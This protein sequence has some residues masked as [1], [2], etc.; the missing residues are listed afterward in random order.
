[1]F[2]LP[3]VPSADDLIDGCFR[4]GSKEAKKIRSTRK[5]KEVRMRLSEEERIHCI[6]RRICGELSSI[7]KSF[8]SYGK[9]PPFYKKLFDIQVDKDEYKK[10]LGALSWVCAR[11]SAIENESVHAVRTGKPHASK[12]FLGKTSSLLTRVSGSLDYLKDVKGKLSS[13][14]VIKELPTLVVAGYPNVG[15]ST[16][17]RNLTGSKIEV[18][19]Y[20]FTTKGLLIGYAKLGHK[21]IQVIDSPGLLDRPMSARNKIELQAVLALQEL[22]DKILFLFDP[23]MEFKPQLELLAEVSNKFTAD[24]FVGVNKADAADKIL[25]SEA[26]NE[27]S[28]YRV[29]ALSANEPE[30]CRRVFEGV[31]A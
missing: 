15:K 12:H 1:M 5:P 16:F 7:V 14:P 6:S 8:P 2:K 21:T 24:L 19:S 13:F 30:D 29:F 3:Y 20:P 18:A 26:L 11:V 9:L 23:T 31:F 4:A 10:S 17:V 25:L 27:L 28:G 22:S